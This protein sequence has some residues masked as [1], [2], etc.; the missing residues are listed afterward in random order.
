LW[1][2]IFDPIT[3]NNYSCVYKAVRRRHSVLYY[4]VA[5]TPSDYP[6][7]FITHDQTLRSPRR[8]QTSSNMSAN[9]VLTAKLIK[10]VTNSGGRLINVKYATETQ[11]WKRNQLAPENQH[12]FVAAVEKADVPAGAT[13]AVM[14]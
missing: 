3:G 1:A 5:S 11:A 13:T 9:R 10:Q 14:V 7:L 8:T 2:S 6:P 12:A 4:Q